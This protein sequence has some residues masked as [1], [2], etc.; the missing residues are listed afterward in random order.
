ME[1][2]MRYS[3]HAPLPALRPW[4][5]CLWTLEGWSSSSAP[6]RLVVPDGRPELIVHYR[7]PFVRRQRRAA[8]VEG[9]ALLVGQL[10]GPIELTAAGAV[11]VIGVRLRPDGLRLL[12]RR[13]AWEMSGLSQPLDDLAP[14]EG[15]EACARVQEASSQRERLAVVESFLLRRAARSERPETVLSHAVDLVAR[16]HGSV[17]VERLAAHLG[18]GRRRLERGF[19]RHVGLT[20]KQFARLTRFQAAIARL[21]R[22]PEVRWADLAADLGFYDQAHLIREFRSFAGLTPTAYLGAE[23]ELAAHFARSRAPL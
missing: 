11:G 3:S 12:D 22:S 17:R 20:P 14:R 7:E 19:R 13:P 15:R 6:P 16:H 9:R 21:A 2:A 5:E 10:D 23:T 8:V 4:V 18:I 1:Q